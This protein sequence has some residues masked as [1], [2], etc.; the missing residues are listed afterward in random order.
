MFDGAQREADQKK[1]ATVRNPQEMGLQW[2][3]HTTWAIIPPI[4]LVESMALFTWNGNSTPQC[5][6]PCLF[7]PLPCRPSHGR[8]SCV[9]FLY[10][11]GR[12][13]QKT[14]KLAAFSCLSIFSDIFQ[15][16]LIQLGGGRARE[17]A[18][19]A[20]KLYSC[21]LTQLHDSPILF[22]HPRF[23]VQVFELTARPFIRGSPP[24]STVEIQKSI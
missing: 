1:T 22:L 10:K 12:K 20:F 21:R 14:A 15:L 3:D 18:D 17:A 19:L 2:S 7:H 11:T 13:L 24:L 8:V 4:I 16:I 5:S 23:R 9:I 6:Q